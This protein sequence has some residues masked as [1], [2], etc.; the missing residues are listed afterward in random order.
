M[1]ATRR[2]FPTLSETMQD[3]G[4][5]AWTLGL[6][7]TQYNSGVTRN[8]LNGFRVYHGRKRE[9]FDDYKGFGPLAH[10]KTR[11]EVLAFLAGYSAAATACAVKAA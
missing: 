8:P 6:T 1:S 2:N 11:N 4:R 5:T 7:L 9:F 10:L 3:A